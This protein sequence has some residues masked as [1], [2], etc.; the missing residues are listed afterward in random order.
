[1]SEVTLNQEQIGRLTEIADLF[2]EI[3]RF[4]IS[5]SSISGIGAIIQVSFG[6]FDEKHNNTKIDITDV[7]N[8]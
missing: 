2:H 8:W 6:L 3:E 1:M 5:S 7:K 4:T